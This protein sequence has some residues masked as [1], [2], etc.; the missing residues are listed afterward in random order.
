MDSKL[1]T[2]FLLLIITDGQRVPSRKGNRVL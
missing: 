1:W 2:I